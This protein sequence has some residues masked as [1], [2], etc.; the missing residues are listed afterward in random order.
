SLRIR[1]AIEAFEQARYLRCRNP[2]AGVSY[3]E[4][5]ACARLRQCQAYAALQCELEC[6]RYEVENDLLPHIAIH[7]DRFTQRL[8]LHLEGETGV[9]HCG[10]E[11][12]RKLAGELCQIRRL[13]ARLQ[14]SSFEAR[15]V[16]QRVDELQQ[17]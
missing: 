4:P 11:R 12:A 9:L 15:K 5:N 1:Y 2:G 16:E 14:S 17:S 7:V 13:V 10:P 3:F 6:V 8:A